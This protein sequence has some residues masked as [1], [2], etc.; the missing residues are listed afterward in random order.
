MK[1]TLA[2]VALALATM[3][4]ARAADV[5]K[6]GRPM[7]I[8]VADDENVGVKIAARNLSSDFALVCGD[9]AAVVTE[10]EGAKISIA[11]VGSARVSTADK[12]RLSGKREAFVLRIGQD[13]VE[14][15]GSDRRG[16]IYGIYEL[17]RR[18]GVS[19]WTWWAD[20]PVEKRS[21]LTLDDEE[22]YSGEPKV[23]L[24]GI[25]LNDEAPALSGWAEEKFGGFN[26]GFYEK[27]FELVLRLRG[28][29][30]WPAMWGRAFYD[31]DPE[32]GRTANDM[33]VVIGTSHHE[34]LGRAHAEWSRYGKGAW[35]YDTNKKVL[36]E[37]W[38]GGMERM[39][40]YE[41]VATIGM[42]GDGDEAMSEDTNIRLLENIVKNQRKIIEQTTGKKAKDVP[43]VWALYKEVQDYYDKGMK[44]PD[45]VTLML[46][47]DNWGNIR[48]LPEP[49][50]T[51]RSG[52]YGMYYHFDYVGGPRNYKWINVTQV[53]RVW[54]Q[55]TMAYRSGIRKVWIVNVGDLKPMEYPIQFFLDLAWDPTAMQAADIARHTEDFCRE[56][57]GE[58][59]ASQIASLLARYTKYNSRRTPEMLDADTYSDN[60]SEWQRVLD[61]YRQLELDAHRIGYLLPAA[62][63]DAYDQL[64][65]FPIAACSNLYELYYAVRR[66]HQ[67][68]AENNIEANQWAQRARQLYERDSLICL[69]YNRDIALGKWN[70]FMDQTHIG[71]TYW[72]QP[73]HNALP[74]LEFV[75]ENRMRR[76]RPVFRDSL[77]YVAI[78]APHFYSKKGQW[79]TIANLGRT[80]DA[81]T[82]LAPDDDTYLTYAFT[83]DYKGEAAV[84]VRLSPSLDLHGQGLRYA[85]SVDGQA[86]QVVDIHGEYDTQQ[87]EQWQGQ[88]INATTTKHT[89]ADLEQHTIR[90]RPLDEGIVLQRI[91]VDLGG[92]LPTY[93]GAPESPRN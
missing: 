25:F 33:G 70:H 76:P 72:Q 93:L 56:L 62:V 45:D 8:E 4:T 58:A 31:D 80:L 36:D 61:D 50:D 68:A 73:D 37:F 59:Q 32:N 79:T 26:A 42:R 84:T 83:T 40:D 89:L 20:A 52:G 85:I 23:E 65:L 14:I 55:M 87:L 69:H 90:I 92:L 27:V 75:P 30:V 39:K 34:P 7:T 17:S 11:T 53:E 49:K 48:R 91:E 35:N 51:L 21:D 88:R 1:K 41:Y 28:N 44:V 82:A 29:F 86:E 81:L 64:V 66:N 67:L 54:E 38:R 71:Y 2:I 74:D 10:A 78:E 22:Y 18:L 46:C 47:D 24:R 63:R 77:G 12:E 60:Y 9:T 6:D 13:G 5:V 19:P 15:V 43:Q 16:T 57:F 3:G